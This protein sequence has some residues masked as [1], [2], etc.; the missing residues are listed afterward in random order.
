[1]NSIH[2]A[3]T[4][5]EAAAIAAA[6]ALFDEETVMQRKVRL[7]AWTIAMR[8]PELSLDEVRDMVKALR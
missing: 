5:E 2:P 3:P 4:P 7:S 6:L 1:M 8:C